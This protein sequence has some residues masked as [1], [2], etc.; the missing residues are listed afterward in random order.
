MSSVKFQD[1]YYVEVVNATLISGDG[2]K[3]VN[4]KDYMLS[5]SIVEDLFTPYI[6]CEIN[7]FDHTSLATNFP[8]VG[9]EFFNITFYTDKEQQTT[10]NFL[11]YKN[12]S[13]GFSETNK[14]QY[15]TLVG[16]SV[17]RIIDSGI[18]FSKS[19]NGLSYA[20]IVDSIFNDYF[21]SLNKKIFIEPTKGVQKFIVPGISPFSAIN[22]CRRR[23]VPVR[24]PYSP[25][26]FF[27]NQEG[28]N[29][30]SLETLYRN[31]L[32][33]PESRILH[34]YV[35]KL[36]KANVEE[37]SVSPLDNLTMGDNSINDVISFDVVEKYNTLDKVKNNVYS[38]TVSY[39]DITTKSFSLGKEHNINKNKN[40]FALGNSKGEF[41]T[42]S[43]IQKFLLGKTSGPVIPVDSARVFDGSTIDYLPDAYGSIKAYL[44][45]MIQER[46]FINIYGNNQIKAGDRFNFGAV[47]PNG[48][49][50]PTTG[51]SYLI[52][53]LKHII[54]FETQPRYIIAMECIRGNFMLP[55]G[56]I[57]NAR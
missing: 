32:A 2:Q 55:I 3:N 14:M 33:K 27:Q 11:I 42:S 8:L 47:L 40:N 13:G 25:Y 26:I 19:F 20:G 17:D 34:S 53:S 36:P 29:Y 1:P 16:V 41:N 12:I 46:L 7:I 15:Y 10:Y 35:Q 57:V 51:G 4:L 49:L 9:E 38:G 22:L 43:F 30:V 48:A 21:S 23:S 50:D 52:S 39:F 54:T 6:H 44:E 18:N 45:L 24:E 28:F 37:R 56:E 31:A 5:I